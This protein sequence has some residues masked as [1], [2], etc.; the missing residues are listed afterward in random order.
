MTEGLVTAATV[1]TRVTEVVQS[2]QALPAGYAAAF[3]APAG[4]VNVASLAINPVNGVITM[5][6]TPQAGGGSV[7]LSPYTGASTG[8]PNATLPFAAPSGP[9]KWQCMAAA[10]TSLVAGVPPGTLPR[11]FAPPECR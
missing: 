6:T 2:G 4:T 9:V 3:I 8:L 10:T 7:V 5:M 1:K 11:R